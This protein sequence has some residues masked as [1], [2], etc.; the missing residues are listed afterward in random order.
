MS[1]S[2]ENKCLESE[3]DAQETCVILRTPEDVARWMR[4][5]DWVCDF[6]GY[7]HWTRSGGIGSN[8]YDTSLLKK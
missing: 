1:L 7:D 8:K 5:K 6:R 2:K 4:E 3:D